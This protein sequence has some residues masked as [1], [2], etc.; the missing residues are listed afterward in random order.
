MASNENSGITTGQPNLHKQDLSELDV[1]KLTALSPEVISRQATINIG[2]IGHVAHGKS[3]V[4]KAISGVQTVRFKNELE[5]NITI[6]LDNL[7]YNDK[8]SIVW[9]PD[10]VGR[11][12]DMEQ[13]MEAL[14][15][16]EKRGEKRK[17]P[18]TVNIYKRKFVV[19]AIESMEYDEVEKEHLFYIKWEGYH[20]ESNTWEPLDHLD[21]A[22]EVL[23]AYLSKVFTD[24][25]LKVLGNKFQLDLEAVTGDMLLQLIPDGDLT[26]IP[27]K[28]QVLKQLLKF[29]H[30]PIHTHYV[31][32]IEDGRKALLSYL[33]ILKRETQLQRLKRWED[34]INRMDKSGTIIKV[35]NNADLEFPPE[36]FCYI[37][38]YVPTGNIE[39][40]DIPD[41]HCECKECAP[42]IKSCCGKQENRSFT[43]TIK[44]RVNVNPGTAIF[45]CNKFCKCSQNCRNRVVQHGRK[46][47][48]CIFRTNNGCGWG[49]K[50]LKKISCGEFICEYVGEVID[51]EEAERRGKAYNAEG[52]TYL[53]DLDYN[54]R[55]NL[56]TVDAA[57]H[58]NVSH[59][60]NHSCDP[61]LGVYATWINCLDPNLPKLALFALREI[62][63][64]EELTFDYMMNIDTPTET[65]TP[66]KGRPKLQTPEKDSMSDRPTCKCAA[67]SCRRYLF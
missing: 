28:L 29:L 56:Y 52:R 66:E 39:L 59:F 40:P 6:K 46:V 4:V 64:G 35:E 20:S 48:L 42:G 36:N 22:D 14:K 16:W 55:D 51:H 45:E 12:V 19:E 65:K 44:G 63:K 3:T 32:K 60:I 24:E 30:M 43:Y 9:P 2:T 15:N 7:Q 57:T 8:G 37:N 38:E 67:D 11:T 1:T 10:L 53:F 41:V 34:I 61:N 27:R 25:I 5:R 62:Q 17:R 31:K 33:L 58:G 49:V 18:S 50:V 23:E 54:S 26:K 21:G 47:P 13:A